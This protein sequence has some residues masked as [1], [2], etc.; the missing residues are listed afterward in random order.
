LWNLYDIEKLYN[1]GGYIYR[2]IWLKDEKKFNINNL[3][4]HWLSNKS[5]VDNIVSLFTLR[6]EPKGNPYYI[7]AYTPPKNVSVPYDYFNNI[8]E[9]EVLVVNDKLLSEVELIKV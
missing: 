1:N 9:N 7:K 3:G 8:E 4:D 2:V 5:D 6:D